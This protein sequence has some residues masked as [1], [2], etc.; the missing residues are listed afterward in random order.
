MAQE[1]HKPV[2]RSD[3]KILNEL[4]RLTRFP[5]KIRVTEPCHKAYVLLQIAVSCRQLV[6]DFSLRVEM[7]EIAEQC[8]RLL[9]AVYDYSNDRGK[10]RLLA[11]CILL[12]RALRFRL[13]EDGS[14]S[15]QHSSSLLEQCREIPSSIAHR[16][17]DNGI[18]EPY[19]VINAR[20]NVTQSKLNC[21]TE[22]I[23]A[24]ISF[25]NRMLRS[26]VAIKTTVEDD[27]LKV[28][29]TPVSLIPNQEISLEKTTKY[30]VISYTVNT[31]LMLLHRTLDYTL[32]PERDYSISVPYTCCP[33]ENIETVVLAVDIV[34]ID[35]KHMLNSTNTLNAGKAPSIVGDD[36]DFETTHATTRKKVI[37][38]ST[39]RK[40]RKN[41]TSENIWKKF[42]YTK[43]DDDTNL[44]STSMFPSSSEVW[45]SEQPELQRLPRSLDFD[46]TPEN[47][48]KNR[49]PNV[50]DGCNIGATRNSEKNNSS[51][52]QFNGPSQELTLVRRKADELNLNTLPVKRL[53]SKQFAD[54]EKSAQF[55]RNRLVQTQQMNTMTSGHVAF[56]YHA[57]TD[58]SFTSLPKNV[59][60]SPAVADSFQYSNGI[61]SSVHGMN[62]DDF[63]SRSAILNDTEYE[64]S[65]GLVNHAVG[66]SDWYAH[67]HHASR[68]VETNRFQHEHSLNDVQH[69]HQSSPHDTTVPFLT[70]KYQ[71][72]SSSPTQGLS[73]FSSTRNKSMQRHPE[74]KIE[75]IKAKENND[76]AGTRMSA[77]RR[78]ATMDNRTETPFAR[79]PITH[80]DTN[81]TTVFNQ[82]SRAKESPTRSIN[83]LFE[84]AFE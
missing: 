68:Y 65:T 82:H 67:P 81:P 46:V 41:K 38:N 21:S 79:M 12:Q 27:S 6:N 77:I 14:T 83:E 4:M 28:T 55:A 33:P 35:A 42:E 73:F 80:Q 70:R 34:G 3:K 30:E 52:H 5:L 48:S 61:N 18:I 57:S 72:K 53:R 16:L 74:E 50:S 13:W 47:G 31:G 7:S 78:L 37:D 84:L 2:R 63:A 44:H 69:Q 39:K 56:P 17:A 26:Q 40:K 76:I 23:K 29:I 64:G 43:P 24:L 49:I 71:P 60:S 25:A 15:G 32:S 58:N 11:T 20:P 62:D 51:K 19:D 45:T 66:K 8:L 36:D 75:E 9:S 1:L 59:L 54:S 10:G 22:D